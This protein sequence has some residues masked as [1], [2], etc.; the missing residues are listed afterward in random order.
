L[1]NDQS[2]MQSMWDQLMTQA[3]YH[4]VPDEKTAK[5]APQPAVQEAPVRANVEGAFNDIVSIPAKSLNGYAD[6]TGQSTEESYEQ[7]ANA[8]EAV[9]SNFYQGDTSFRFSTP[10]ANVTLVPNRY[11][12]GKPWHLMFE[13]RKDVRRQDMQPKAQEVALE[14]K[15]EIYRMLTALNLTW[16][17]QQR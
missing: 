16:T 13:L 15:K 9:R 7:I 12:T 2:N 1:N 5:P 3:D 8:F 6:M 10:F 11:E 17:A 4:I 14:D